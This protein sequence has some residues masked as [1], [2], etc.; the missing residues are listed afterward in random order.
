MSFKKG[1]TEADQIHADHC[2]VPTYAK[3]GRY[4]SQSSSKN[5]LQDKHDDL[6]ISFYQDPS[7]PFS[8]IVPLR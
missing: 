4:E 6:E 1:C 2:V 8:L 3:R 7:L 5:P